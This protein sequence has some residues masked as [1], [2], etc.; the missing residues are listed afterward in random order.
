MKRVLLD[1]AV[2]ALLVAADGVWRLLSQSNGVIQSFVTLHIPAI[3]ISWA[4][5]VAAMRATWA[6]F[7]TPRISSMIVGVVEWA[8]VLTG[9]HVF[10]CWLDTV[11]QPQDNFSTVLAFTVFTLLLPSL[12]ISSMAYVLVAAARGRNPV[13]SE[14]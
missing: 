10:L 9:V 13:A 6:S 5:I 2:V 14:E 1:L 12:I 8:G 4:S 3:W 11:W 7:A